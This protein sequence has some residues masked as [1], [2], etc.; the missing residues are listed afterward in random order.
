MDH[1]SIKHTIHPLPYITLEKETEVYST[2]KL[3]GY[4]MHLVHFPAITCTC[5]TSF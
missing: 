3:A 4:C 1:T 5:K 2:Y